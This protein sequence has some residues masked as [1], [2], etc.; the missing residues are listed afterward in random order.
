MIYNKLN[1]GTWKTLDNLGNSISG[2]K[3]IWLSLKIN[4]KSNLH[5]FK[6]EL[7][8]YH[9]VIQAMKVNKDDIEDPQVN[10]L[11][12]GIFQYKFQNGNSN[13]FIDMKCN[14]SGY[15]EEFTEIVKE[16]T[17]LILENK[18][19]PINA[20]NHV[21]SNWIS[22][23][24]N[25]NKY[26]LSKEEQI[27]LICELLT[28][29]NLCKINPSNALNTW[30]GP[31]GEKHDFNFTDWVLE[32]KGTRKSNRAHTVNGIDQLK[33]PDNKNLAFLSFIVSESNN[34]KSMNLPSLIDIVISRHFQMKPSFTVRFNELL[35]GTGYSPVHSEIYRKFNI[36]IMESTLF[37]VDDK[38]PKLTSSMLCLPL[39]SRVS[40]IRYDISL[41]G[42]KGK[43]LN[44]VNWG[45]Y[46]Y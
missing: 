16:I 40:R 21:I 9:F 11:Q 25:Q 45:N 14:I 31:L 26:V 27:G 33:P 28:F 22:F 18:I 1:I 15:L 20:I 24:A 46:F 35:A 8:N 4:E 23:W 2:Y 42:I 44:E 41:E 36:E 29:N 37:I 5:I 34:I 6:D 3:S 38:F 12:I 7:D 30:K 39:S 32:V 10:G 19:K 13:Q 43:K 17:K